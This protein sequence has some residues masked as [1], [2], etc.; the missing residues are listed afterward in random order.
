MRW[1]NLDWEEGQYHVKE[2]L[3]EGLFDT[4]KTPTSIRT[5]DLTPMVV[6]TL[7]THK[8]RQ[9]QNRLTEGEDYQDSDLTFCSNDGSPITNTKAL[10]NVFNA[11]LKAAECPS[12]QAARFEAHLRHAA[13]QPERQ[14][15]VYSETIRSCLC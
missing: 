8:A 10:R 14:P 2:R 9:N 15:Q 5:V 12:Y 3:Y 1:K 7:R 13:N 11:S 6:E 4:P